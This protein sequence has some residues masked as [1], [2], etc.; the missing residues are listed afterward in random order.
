MQFVGED[1]QPRKRLV[2][3]A[4]QLTPHRLHAFGRAQID[5]ND[6]AGQILR[7]RVGKLH[8]GNDLHVG[9]AGEDPCQI[10]A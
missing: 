5:I 6:D 7:R 9:N 4:E 2:T 10:S 3:A 8:R 1:E